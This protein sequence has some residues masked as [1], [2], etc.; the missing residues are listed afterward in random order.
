MYFAGITAMHHL[1]R[2]DVQQDKAQ[3]PG[4]NRKSFGL[5][6][7]GSLGIIDLSFSSSQK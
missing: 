6:F 3:Y 1:S 4:I 7:I 5:A 2:T